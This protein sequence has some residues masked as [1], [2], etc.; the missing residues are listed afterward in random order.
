[1]V[2]SSVSKLGSETG[3]IVT[4]GLAVALGV[5]AGGGKLQTMEQNTTTPLYT[6][7]ETR[8]SSTGGQRGRPTKEQSALR[9]QELLNKALDHFLERGFAGTSI[10]LIVD[11]LGMSRRTLY[12]RYGDKLVL[13]KA[14]LQSA[15]E[16]LVV[17]IEEL[18]A[19][20]T[21]NLEQTL[22]NISGAIL[23]RMLSRPGIRLTRIA[24]AELFQMPEIAQ[25]LYERMCSG[26]T[27]FLVDLFQRRL[28]KVSA[29]EAALAF[30]S[31]AVDGMFYT[32]MWLN[33]PEEEVESHLNYRIGLFVR[34][35]LDN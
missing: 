7:T 5:D 20:E 4:F 6:G 18:K 1:M 28:T 9:D 27:E 24:N 30:F 8:R 17:P 35:A 14:A 19:A 10:E 16:E 26:V 3:T 25:Y 11:S 15:I 22:R 31:I 34:G 29:R 32:K 23:R 12:A 21:E 33:M 2:A 13:F